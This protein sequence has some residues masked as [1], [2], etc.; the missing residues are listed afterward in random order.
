MTIV[1]A[2]DRVDYSLLETEAP[3]RVL[4]VE[5][6]PIA[7]AFLGAQ[8][9]ELGHV[10]ITAENGQQALSVIDSNR[11]Y[12]DVVLMDREMPVMDG[13]TAVKHMKND[14]N[15]RDIPVIMI[16]GADTPDDFREGLDVGIF[17]YLTKPVGEEMLRSVL[18]AAVRDS[19]QTKTLVEELHKHRTS[20][21]LIDT[22]KFRFQTLADAE[23][24][25]VFMANCF[26]DRQ[27]VLPGLGE[28]LIN[29]VEH[30]NLE[31]GYEQKS[32]LIDAGTWRTEIN[33]RQQLSEFKDKFATATVAH[34]ENGTYV[35]IEDQ[36]AGFDWQKFMKIDPARAGDNHGRGIALAKAKS[37]DKLSYGNDGRKAVGFVNREKPLE[38]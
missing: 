26:S 20:F 7:M 8:I 36:G 27:R 32:V 31:I 6:D 33:R 38:W 34:K 30:G 1:A 22:C 25:A 10:M 9:A 14:R 37:F 15:L 2:D 13:L 18:A 35:V 23:S 17:Y 29:A 16:T 28:L 4:A 11:E 3:V 24:L 5:D 12:I 21:D 19:R